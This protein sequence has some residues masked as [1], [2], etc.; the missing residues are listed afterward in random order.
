MSVLKMEIVL[1]DSPI[2]LSW[3]VDFFRLA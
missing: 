2:V 1:F 3:H